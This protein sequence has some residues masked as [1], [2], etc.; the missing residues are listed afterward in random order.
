MGA[1]FKLSHP[2]YQQTHGRIWDRYQNFSTGAVTVI[3]EIGKIK[4]REFIVAEG[5]ERVPRSLSQEDMEDIYD[6][7]ESEGQP[8]AERGQLRDT[9][10]GAWFAGGNGI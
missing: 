9:D 10:F 6:Y 3:Y 7:A 1:I 4:A 5:I 8:Q 2:V